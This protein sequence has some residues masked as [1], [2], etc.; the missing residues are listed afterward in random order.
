MKSE[1]YRLKA[2]TLEG[3]GQKVF[4]DAVQIPINDLL[5]IKSPES[6]LL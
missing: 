3:K 2:V 4:M 1:D 6:A 5:N